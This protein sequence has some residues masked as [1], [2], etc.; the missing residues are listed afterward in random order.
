MGLLKKSS[1]SKSDSEKSDS[2][3][4]WFSS[5]SLNK[6][7]NDNDSGNGKSSAPGPTSLVK[8]TESFDKRVLATEQNVQSEIKQASNRK[9][10]RL[11]SS[12]GVLLFEG[13]TKEELDE[14]SMKELREVD[15]SIDDMDN[16]KNGTDFVNVPGNYDPVK[17]GFYSKKAK[18]YYDSDEDDKL[19]NNKNSNDIGSNPAF[20][21]C[22]GTLTD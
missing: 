9:D 15:A 11:Q 17:S 16:N 18:N 1:S 4:T 8:H 14:Y 22:F 3:K 2:K 10:L 12:G 13:M 7:G 21:G 5:R 19:A 6:R 20:C